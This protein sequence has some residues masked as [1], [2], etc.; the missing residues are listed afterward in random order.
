M[1]L[2]VDFVVDYL[3][4]TFIPFHG[5]RLSAQEDLWSSRTRLYRP[6]IRG[7][8]CT[9]T[10]RSSSSPNHTLTCF[11]VVVDSH[12][13]PRL[14]FEQSLDVAFLISDSLKAMRKRGS[15][16]EESLLEGLRGRVEGRKLA[17]EAAASKENK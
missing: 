15:V 11:C 1:G 7:M 5:S 16:S 3:I 8:M 4:I 9:F 2:V 10:V 13:D 14:N 12:C 6:I 17:Q